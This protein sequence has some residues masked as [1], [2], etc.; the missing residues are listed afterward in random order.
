MIA[1]FAVR[2]ARRPPD[3]RRTYGYARLEALAQ[4][5]LVR[6]MT[7]QIPAHVVAVLNY[8][9]RHPEDLSAREIGQLIGISHEAVIRIQKAVKALPGGAELVRSSVAV[10][11]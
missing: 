8:T 3:A 11:A 2:L 6:G 4:E 7:K 10:P 9:Y 5:L 1:L